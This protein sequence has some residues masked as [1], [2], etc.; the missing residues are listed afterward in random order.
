M[1]EQRIYER[2][3]RVVSSWR[4]GLSGVAKKAISDHD[5]TEL[6]AALAEGIHEASLP[7]AEPGDRVRW[8]ETDAECEA[9]RVE[10]GKVWGRWGGEDAPESHVPEGE[11]VVV[12][13]ARKPGVLSI[14]PY[15]STHAVMLDEHG[16]SLAVF[17]AHRDL[18]PDAQRAACEGVRAALL[19]AL[20]A[21]EPT[22]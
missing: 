10:D 17:E 3:W 12:E 14:K 13:P 18:P 16:S 11:I 15:G 2:V 1:D 22:P 19:R 20:A 9:T 7:R 21:Q 8:T 6:R 4:I 5:M